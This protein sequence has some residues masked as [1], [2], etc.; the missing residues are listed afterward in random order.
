ME[1]K[2]LLFGPIGTSIMIA[3]DVLESDF[4][5]AEKSEKDGHRATIDKRANTA[6]SRQVGF[7]AFFKQFSAP[8]QNPAL[9]QKLSP[10]TCG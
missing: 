6:C 9:K 2:E 7:C 1:P 8:Q 10:P 3:V 4:A 5:T